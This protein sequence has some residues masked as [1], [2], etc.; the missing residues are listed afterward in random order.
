MPTDTPPDWTQVDIAVP[1]LSARVPGI[2][3][4]GFRYGVATPMSLTMVT[5][6]SV[7]L[8]LDLSD[9]DGG[10]V[11]DSDGGRVQTS[12]A[13]GLLPGEIGVTGSGVGE[14]LQIRL[15][16]VVAAAVLG[17]PSDLR[18]A[19]VSLGDLW[20]R[21]PARRLEDH[22]R[23][24]AS[25][26]DR[27]AAAL[28]F[29]DRQATSRRAT[30]A[31]VA[32]AWQRTLIGQGQVR[33]DALA[34]DVGWTRKRLWSRFCSQLGLS[35]KRAAQLVRFDRAAHLLAAGHAP[36]SVAAE[37]GYADQSHLHREVRAFAGATPTAVAAA[38][39]LEIDDVAWP[40]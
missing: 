5:H 22:L 9:D 11:Y 13:V 25:W 36:A 24:A 33:V 32:Y 39:W 21:G 12:V 35:P 15:S 2:R 10:I 26:D 19:L 17:S 20:G 14:C 28:N 18:G 27:F 6:P 8:L 3:M 16:P 1:R 30:D 37:T 23:A 34:N 31:E 7:T 38:P 29:L 40:S 4:A